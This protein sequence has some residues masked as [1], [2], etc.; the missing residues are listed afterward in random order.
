M[1]LRRSS[2]PRGGGRGR[3]R[4]AAG[5]TVL[6]LAL[7]GGI[8]GTANASST[9]PTQSAQV[10]RQVDAQR[11]L[12]TYQALQQNLYLPQYHLYQ[13]D[14]CT[15]T[16][17]YGTLWP[18]SSAFAATG[19]VAALG[20]AAQGVG[21]D[22][23]ARQQ[24][25]TD[26]YDA[27]EVGPDGQA[28]PPAY[29]SEV[30][31]PLGAGA[32]TYFDDDAWISLDEMYAYGVTNDP[33]D[34]RTAENI[35]HFVTT[36]WDSNASDP[37]PGGVIWEDVAGSTRNAVSNAPNAEV[38]LLLYRA[39][40]R[41]SYLNWATKMYD[42][43][44]S[45]LENSDYLYNDHINTDGTINTALWSYNQGTMIG[46]GALLYQITGD[47]AYLQQ[48]EQTAAAAVSYYGANNTLYTQPDV[49]N[50]IMFRNMFYLAGITGN[51][52]YRQLAA[53]YAET[54]WTQDRQ[55]DGLISDPDATGG[56]AA[57]NQTAPMAV[58]Y[59]LLAGAP[60]MIVPHQ[61]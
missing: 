24:G 11:A 10:D 9:Q 58:I 45:C 42:W 25:L 26:Y 34:L 61:G 20:G 55:S 47:H 38:G 49:F 2:E 1:P 54:A 16:N 53:S 18:F 31:P 39:T 43:T 29:E 6:S 3:L 33:A 23:S 5:A 40:G 41:A 59:A 57:V 35:F 19:Y 60:P 50:E 4:W 36:G 12:L 14:S 17:H 30:G 22:L 8:A 44:R 27:A 51:Q 46:A 21:A 56:E 7:A 48:A 15:T 52:S 28:Q 37:C 13:C 32:P